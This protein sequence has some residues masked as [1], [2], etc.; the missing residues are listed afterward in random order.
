MSLA[1]LFDVQ[2][3]IRSLQACVEQAM[4]LACLAERKGRLET[5]Q[6]HFNRALEL[7]RDAIHWQA[8]A[9]ATEAES[10]PVDELPGSLHNMGNGRW[11]QFIALRDLLAAFRANGHSPAV[12]FELALRWAVDHEAPLF[13]NH[14]EPDA[15][16][17]LSGWAGNP[18]A[19]VFGSRT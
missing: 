2:V 19:C 14:T 17:C 16:E 13:E 4:L 7:D 18:V 9:A 8:A 12:A 1:E 5:A 15:V 10:L 3:E 6:H 11:C